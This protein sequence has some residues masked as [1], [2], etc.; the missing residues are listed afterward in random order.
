MADASVNAAPTIALLTDFGWNDPYVGQ[1]KGVLR[2]LAPEAEVIDLSHGVPAYRVETGAFFLASTFRYFPEGTVFVAVVDP[3]VGTQKRD[4]LVLVGG[5]FTFVGP[6]NGILSL[7]AESL[8]AT[9]HKVH[10]WRLKTGPAPYVRPTGLTFAARDIMAPLAARLCRGGSPSEAGEPVVPERILRPIWVMP[11]RTSEGILASVLHA[12]HF[13]NVILNLAN[14]AWAEA[15]AASDVWLMI[16]SA[17]AKA[18][19]Q[20]KVAPAYAELPP[21]K[22]GL[23]PGGQGYLELAMYCASAAAELRLKTGDIVHLGISG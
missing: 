1:M 14:E 7:A 5:G 19:L 21:G 2:A 12:D 23:V 11:E 22:A 16:S 15:L 6:D 18:A 9:G 13:G 3:W 4:I 10:A 8:D 20:L 17:G